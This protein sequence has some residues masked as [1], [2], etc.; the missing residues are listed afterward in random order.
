MSF[1]VGDWVKDKQLNT[2]Y[3]IQDIF[4]DGYSWYAPSQKLEPRSLWDS[5]VYG[6]PESVDNLELWQ[7]EEGEWCWYGFEL[8]QVIGSQQDHIKIC[9]QKSDSYE[10]IT[11]G[12][13][14][15][16]I[17]NLPTCVKD[18]E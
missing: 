15:P 8:V 9:R 6:T 7:P 14:E 13:L 10:E 12:Q 3:K 17:G 18:K 4:K 5:G 1:K 2:V 16:F 11:K